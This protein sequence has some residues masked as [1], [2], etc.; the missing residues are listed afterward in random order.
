M[1]TPKHF[2][3]LLRYLT[4]LRL[5]LSRH[6]LQNG[7]ANLLR[8]DSPLILKLNELCRL[9]DDEYCSMLASGEDL[10]VEFVADLRYLLHESPFMSHAHRNPPGQASDHETL[11]MVHEDPLR[12][13]TALGLFLNYYVLNTPPMSA[14]RSRT[15][16]FAQ[17]LSRHIS[18]T[19]GGRTAIVVALGPTLELELALDA[20]PE[21]MRRLSITIADTE[22]ASLDSYLAGLVRCQSRHGIRFPISTVCLAKDE[23]LSSSA[24]GFPYGQCTFAYAPDTFE[25]LNDSNAGLLLKNLVLQLTPGGELIVANMSLENNHFRALMEIGLEWH[26]VYRSHSQLLRLANGLPGM[27]RL[28]VDEI[29]GGIVK[30]LRIQ[31]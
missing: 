5:V 25:H 1:H 8:P 17:F 26:P 29:C 20:R 27:Q 21:L 9:C 11:R 24:S 14:V 30:F 31:V 12:G 23:L 4:D 15:R 18:G 22:R 19:C 16:Y 28:A 13:E 7:S 10:P 2:R 6:E 3:S